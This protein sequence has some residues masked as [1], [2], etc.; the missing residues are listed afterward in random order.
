MSK[1]ELTLYSWGDF[2]RDIDAVY[3]K[4]SNLSIR[5]CTAWNKAGDNRAL[6]AEVLKGHHKNMQG[7]KRL[8]IKYHT[9]NII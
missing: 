1:K 2:K 7:V 3:S 9:S 4:L 8:L 5:V 6:I